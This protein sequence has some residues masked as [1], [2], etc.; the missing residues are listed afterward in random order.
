MSEDRE[1]YDA[2]ICGADGAV[3]RVFA[4]LTAPVLTYNA[5]QQAMD[6]PAGLPNP[7]TVNLYQLSSV[8]GRGRQKK[9]TLYVR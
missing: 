1:A 8:V 9:E 6:F 3:M 7:L 4:G 5:A 2:E